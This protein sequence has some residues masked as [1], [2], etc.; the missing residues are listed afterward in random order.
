MNEALG[1]GQCARGVC[2]SR[3]CGPEQGGDLH[4]SKQETQQKPEVLQITFI[5]GHLN[6]PNQ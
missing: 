3:N 5:V 2:Y 6:G 4:S 1:K